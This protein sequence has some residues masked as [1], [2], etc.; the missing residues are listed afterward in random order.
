MG[1]FF[2]LTQ[3]TLKLLPP[4]TMGDASLCPDP[5]DHRWVHEDRQ[6]DDRDSHAPGTLTASSR[7]CWVRREEG[8]IRLPLEEE[9]EAEGHSRNARQPI[10][11]RR[12]NE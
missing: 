11:I 8:S 7:R 4:G 10:D 2:F 3:S 1:I 6:I 5:R 9:E 12:M